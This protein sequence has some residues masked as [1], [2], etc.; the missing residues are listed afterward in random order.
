MSNVYK[1]Y[2]AYRRIMDKLVSKAEAKK[3]KVSP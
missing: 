1:Y 2:I 3:R